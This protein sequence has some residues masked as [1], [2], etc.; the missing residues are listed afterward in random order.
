[1]AG[2]FQVKLSG[3]WKNYDKDEDKI[4]KRAYLAGFPNAKYS[5][6]GQNYEVDF[7]KMQQKNA[8]TGKA[9]DIR[10]PYKW[11]APGEPITAA[12]PTFCITVP[13][14]APGTTISVPHPK[15]KTQ[16][17]AVNV[18]PTA[19]VGQAMLVP[20]PTGPPA[21]LPAEEVKGEY[22][23]VAPKDEKEKKKWSTGAKVAAA[24]GGAL[25]V[26]GL[27][28]GGA[29]LGEHIAEEGWDATMA[30][31]GDVATSAGEGIADGAE[32]AVD[33]VG[34]AADATGDFIMDLF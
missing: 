17:I 4:L 19:K 10:A 31:L 13:P 15:D 16:M 1:M 29:M 7:K 2:M 32:A 8:A 27:A 9:R 21:A 20:I 6:R 33:W 11:K 12:G 5:L 30:D 25:V 3:D 18:P 23:P 34:D 22:K 14:G 26:G 28:V 24:T